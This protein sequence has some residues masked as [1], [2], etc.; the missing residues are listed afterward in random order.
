MFIILAAFR[1]HRLTLR[2][3][4]SFASREYIIEGYEREEWIFSS[5][6]I[7]YF[8]DFNNQDIII[9]LKRLCPKQLHITKVALNKIQLVR[10][11]KRKGSW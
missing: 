10:K 5:F 3:L 11:K 2:E 7:F 8:F 6:F 1:C 9:Q 4:R